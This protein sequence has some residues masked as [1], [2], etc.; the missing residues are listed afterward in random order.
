MREGLAE[1]MDIREVYTICNVLRQVLHVGL[2]VYWQNDLLYSLAIS[3]HDFL[4]DAMGP[5]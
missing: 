2:V 1:G 3:H 4:F 5:Q